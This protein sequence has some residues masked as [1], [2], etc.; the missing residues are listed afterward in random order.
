MSNRLSLD[1]QTHER[2][3]ATT[4]GERNIFSE[5]MKFYL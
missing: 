3:E 4:T 1:N 5:P 2:K